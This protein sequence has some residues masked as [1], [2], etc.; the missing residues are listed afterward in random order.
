MNRIV[1]VGNGYVD[2]DSAGSRV[3]DRLST[4]PIPPGV[5]VLNAGL[6]GLDVLPLAEGMDRVIF[7]DNVIGCAPA[8]SVVL[9]GAEQAAANAPRAFGHDAGLA[10]ALAMLPSVCDHPPR[11][12]HVVGL[13]G[14][15]SEHTIDQAAQL[16]LELVCERGPD[17]TRA[18]G[19]MS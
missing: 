1:C 3:F 8:G 7:V 19:G 12:V 4:F 9:L 17:A 6:A 10:Y 5:E 16:A 13:E 18:M 14:P 15:V 11:V 2:Q